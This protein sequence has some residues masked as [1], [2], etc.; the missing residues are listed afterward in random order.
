MREG[1][2][3]VAWGVNLFVFV[4]V[5]HLPPALNSQHAFL[6]FCSLKGYSGW[7]CMIGSL[8][9]K[10]EDSKTRFGKYKGLIIEHMK[11]LF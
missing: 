2:C 4:S 5:L 7:S 6:I 10:G 3:P 8:E 9:G 1:F 11:W